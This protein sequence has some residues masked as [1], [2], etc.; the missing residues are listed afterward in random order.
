MKLLK[1]SLNE[2]DEKEQ[3][4]IEKMR[5]DKMKLGQQASDLTRQ[6]KTYK[7]NPEQRARLSKQVTDLKGKQSDLTLKMLGAKEKLDAKKKA[8]QVK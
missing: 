1:Q 7:G 2:A 3:S 5:A 6:K 8:R 4:D